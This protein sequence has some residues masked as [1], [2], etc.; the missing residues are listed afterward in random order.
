MANIEKHISD[1]LCLHDCVII[2]G[3]GGFVA[4]YKQATL[5]NERN[6]LLP[7][8]KA[9]GFNQSLS[10]NDG[11]LANHISRREGRSY[12]ESIEQINS[13]VLQVK[14]RI[15]NGEPVE[16]TG[17]GTFRKDASGIM[18]FTPNEHNNLFPNTFGLEKIH[19]EPL[20]HISNIQKHEEPVR[21]LLRSRS[22]RYWA[23]VAAVIA[24]LF[25]FTPDL[26]VPDHQQIDTGNIISTISETSNPKQESSPV[27]AP[28]QGATESDATTATNLEQQTA[29]SSEH[30]ES[31]S[32]FHL[33]AASFIKESPA[34]EILTKLHND[35]FTEATILSSSNGRYR[36][37][38]FSFSEREKAVKKLYALRTKQQ[39]QNVW[40][41]TNS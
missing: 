13:F 14:A 36:V 7:P 3:I 34:K 40:L 22:P 11:L 27:I 10:H 8:S 33:I 37:S 1:L 20:H 16:F 18:F 23:S 28:K 35:G 26:K 29:N 5:V 39:F 4:N 25:L 17:I 12:A 41:L 19:F 32:S 2:P 24:G 6:L 38:L 9:I 31:E 15:K 21:R 30:N